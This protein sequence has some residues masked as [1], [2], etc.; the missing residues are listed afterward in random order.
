MLGKAYTF[1][2]E[3]KEAEKCLER[4]LQKNDKYS[5]IYY[6][7][8]YTLNRQKKYVDGLKMFEKGIAKDSRNNSF[9]YLG[10]SQGFIE[11]GQH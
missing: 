2:G 6:Q 11:M 3:Y 4:G 8:G 5:P 7:Y 9:A 10:R 1:V